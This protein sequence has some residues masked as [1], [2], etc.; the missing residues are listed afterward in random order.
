MKIKYNLIPAIVAILIIISFSCA[1]PGFPTGGP[2]DETPPVLKKSTP[3]PN[4][5]NYQKK[6]VTIEFD[7]NIALDNVYQKFI[8]S[9]PLKKRANIEARANKLRIKFDDEEVLQENATYT[10]DFA[11]AIKDN[12]EGNAI[13]SFVFSFS[14]GEII[15]SFAIMGNLWDAEDL[16][17]IQGALIL[18]HKNLTDTVF[19]TTVPE[20]LAKTD[21]DGYFALKNLSPGDYK[22][23]A[24][25]DANNNYIFDQ[26]GEQ[27]AWMD[28]AVHTAMEYAQFADTISADSIYYHDELVYTPN[29]LRLFL[30]TE[31]NGNQYMVGNERKT[32]N[33]M[34]F[35]FNSK[36]DS[37]KVTPADT[38]VN[39]D[40]LIYEPSVNNDTV[41]V[42]IKDSAVYKHDT[43]KVALNYMGLDTLQNPTLIK[44]TLTMYYFNFDQPKERRR[45]KDKDEPEP[46]PMLNIDKASSKVDLYSNFAFIMPTP[47]D[48]I[49]KEKLHLL[50][51]EDSIVN[52]LDF[53]LQQDDF[54]KR[55]YWVK[56]RWVPGGSYNFITDSLAIKDIYGW[57]TDSINKPF[58]V[59]TLDSYGLLLLDIANPQEDWLIQLQDNNGKTLQQKYVPKNGKLAFQYLNPK[60]FL[61]KLVVD[62]N[63]NG[64]WDTGDYENKIQPEEIRYYPEPVSVRANWDIEVKWDP[65][66]FDIYDFVQ[67]NRKTKKQ[68]N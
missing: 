22:I 54:F 8:T 68:Q 9:P 21:K 47:V 39:D 31:D 65:S 28:T 43:L 6:V 37:F 19:T 55:K 62:K 1:N 60:T 24:L 13:P 18:A 42:W 29:H 17:P 56:T 33:T 38:L 64:K 40:W 14:T 66:T 49:D 58:S 32:P 3:E 7:E 53:E 34:S 20:R 16:S 67:K 25:Q 27:I 50:Y 51:K 61:I 11:D 5:L 48:H 30:C 41:L 57:H 59:K 2:K 10:L 44:D 4:A 36:L 45:K 12:N 63:M 23:Y 26:P 35:F 15:D 52:E 46:I